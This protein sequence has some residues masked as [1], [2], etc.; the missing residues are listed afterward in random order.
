MAG[1]NIED[2]VACLNCGEMM[3]LSVAHGVSAVAVPCMKKNWSQRAKCLYSVL[4]QP[5]RSEPPE[6]LQRVLVRHQSAYSGELMILEG[7]VR[8]HCVHIL[9][10][11]LP[12]GHGPRLDRQ[13]GH[14]LCGQ[15]WARRHWLASVRRQNGVC[16]A[17]CC[18]SQCLIFLFL[19]FFLFCVSNFKRQKV[20]A[21]S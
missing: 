2:Y 16:L 12:P 17:V 4:F 18:S 6:L 9:W 15:A 11:P 13:M 21:G 5:T 7:S 3:Q 20:D 10:R 8:A 1:A 19:F 14:A